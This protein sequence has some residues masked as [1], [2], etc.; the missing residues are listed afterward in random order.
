MVAD[1]EPLNGLKFL[2]MSGIDIQCKLLGAQPQRGDL[3]LAHIK[4]D[5]KSPPWSRASA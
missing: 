1:F 5:L 3:A 4:P 2:Q